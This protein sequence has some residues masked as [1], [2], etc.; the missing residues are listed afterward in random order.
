MRLSIVMHTHSRFLGRLADLSDKPKRCGGQR[1]AHQRD[2]AAEE[3]LEVLLPG[4]TAADH[5]TQHTATSCTRP[6]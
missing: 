3:R 6:I 1:V 5:A 2:G 4:L